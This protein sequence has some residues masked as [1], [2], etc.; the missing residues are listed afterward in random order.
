MHALSSPIAFDY[1]TVYAQTRAQRPEIIVELAAVDT[2][3]VLVGFDTAAFLVD[4]GADV[5]MLN[6]S[7]AARLGLDLSTM[8]RSTVLGVGGGKAGV[9]QSELLARLCGRWTRIPV[10][11]DPTRDINL[12]GREGAFDALRLAFLQS[13][14]LMLA[15]AQ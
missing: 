13:S 7:F 1:A 10:L 2:R 5:T 3:G 8:A 14:R 15:A 6:D 9:Y 11:F 4:S 12:L